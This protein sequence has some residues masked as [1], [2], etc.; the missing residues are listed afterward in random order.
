MK[1][2]NFQEH[3]GAPQKFTV[4]PH[5]PCVNK[6]FYRLSMSVKVCGAISL[7]F[8]LWLSNFNKGLFNLVNDFQWI[9]ASRP[10]F[11]ERHRPVIW[12]LISRR[13]RDSFVRDSSSLRRTQKIVCGAHCF[14]Q[15]YFFFKCYDYYILIILAMLLLITES[16]LLWDY[17]GD[18]TLT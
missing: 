13:L 17:G 11:A 7:W 10:W 4:C 9:F 2:P 14:H 6:Y 16:S 8:G 15:C 18:W 1:I 12:G 5:V 3:F